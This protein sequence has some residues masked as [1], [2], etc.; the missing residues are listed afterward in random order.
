MRYLLALILPP[1]AVFFCAGFWM[2]LLN[3]LFW[4][5]FIIPG[6]IHAL[7]VVSKYHADR[8]HQEMLAALKK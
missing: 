4:L 1:V 8:R 3:L 2:A 7:L 6:I 5:C